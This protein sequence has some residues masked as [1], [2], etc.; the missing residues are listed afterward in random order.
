MSASSADPGLAPRPP[1]GWNS[2]DCYGTQLHERDLLANAEAMARLLKPSGWRYVVVDIQW[3]E[4]LPRI[5]GDGEV[6]WSLPVER[7]FPTVTNRGREG[8]VAMDGF[9]RLHPSPE[10]FPSSVGGKGFKPLADT[11]HGLGLG[12]GIHLMRGIPRRAVWDR[13]PIEGT[14]YTADQVADLNAICVWNADNFGVDAARPGAQ[15]W[16]DSLAR[17]YASWDVD[18]VKADDML[19]EP[20]HEGEIGLLSSALARCGRPIVL[21]LSPGMRGIHHVDHLRRSA[22]LWR[23]GCDFWDQWEGESGFAGLKPQFVACAEWAP[24][25][26]A[27]HWPDADM[28]PLGRIGRNDARGPERM[29][30]FTPGEQVSLMTLCSMCRSPLMYGGSIVDIDA[31]TL[32]LLTNPEVLRVNQESEGNR[33]LFRR[34]D[35]VAWTARE[36]ATGDVY[37]ALFNLAD[38]PGTVS[39]TLADLGLRGLVE[40]RDLWKRRNEERAEGTISRDIGPHGAVLL[41]LGPSKALNPQEEP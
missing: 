17:L 36:P 7:R 32:E 11:V 16:Y 21:S 2:W 26:Q 28:L 10:K 33:Q 4:P 19:C 12:F 3:Y 23:I 5:F 20:Y 13:T 1:L 9:G 41:K 6:D 30:R 40:V 15:E 31:W 24:H 27:G 8:A 37:L 35:Q 29:T 18:F 25:I 22:H 34:G 39:V 14:R 38:S